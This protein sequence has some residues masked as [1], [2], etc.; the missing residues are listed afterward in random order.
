MEEI[1]RLLCTHSVNAEL[2]ISPA[3]MCQASEKCEARKIRVCIKY[4]VMQSV[5]ML[6]FDSTSI[7]RIPYYFFCFVESRRGVFS[8]ALFFGTISFLLNISAIKMCSPT[9]IY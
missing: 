7:Q 8:S 2:E 3:A 5:V 6:D 9:Y 4:S 1:A